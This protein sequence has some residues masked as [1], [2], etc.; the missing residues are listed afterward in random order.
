MSA[1]GVKERLGTV[2][3]DKVWMRQARTTTPSFLTNRPQ[4]VAVLKPYPQV[5]STVD[6]G[7]DSV[8]S[9]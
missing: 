8:K 5:A 6:L 7:E 3:E 1:T 9:S 4:I 2:A